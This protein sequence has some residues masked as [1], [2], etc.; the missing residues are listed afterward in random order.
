MTDDY[1]V[2][3]LARETQRSVARME[4]LAARLE[5]GQFVNSEFFRLYKEGVEQRFL[6]LA[7][8]IATKA[9]TTQ[10][11]ALTTEVNSLKDDRKWLVRALLLIFITAVASVVFAASGGVPT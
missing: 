10:V 3:E 4:A 9:E 11:V 8:E 2:G 6:A 1:T 7:N 5:G